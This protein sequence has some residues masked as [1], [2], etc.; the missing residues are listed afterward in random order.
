MR[1]AER[2]LADAGA[3]QYPVGRWSTSR[4]RDSQ[5]REIVTREASGCSGRRGDQVTRETGDGS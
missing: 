4:H 1:G 3:F 2:R 5:C